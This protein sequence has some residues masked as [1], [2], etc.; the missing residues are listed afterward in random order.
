[1]QTESIRD[2]I[3]A[4][5]NIRKLKVEREKRRLTQL[6]LSEIVGI[7]SQGVIS[8]IE[9]G[10]RCKESDY[11][12]LAEYFGWE[13]YVPCRGKSEKDGLN[14]GELLLPFAMETRKTLTRRR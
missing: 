1:M 5:T 2:D 10:K 4:M 13:K 12:K 14:K 3:V 11:N 7:S 9:L 8:A 6:E